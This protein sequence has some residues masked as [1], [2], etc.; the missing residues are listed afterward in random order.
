MSKRFNSIFYTEGKFGKGFRE[1]V[2]RGSKNLYSK[3]HY[4][5][6]ITP[7]DLPEDYVKFSSRTIWYMDGYVKTSG[8]VDI[9]YTSLK[10]NHLFKDDYLDVSY[11]NKI[12]LKRTEYGEQTS[13][14]DFSICGNDIIP[15]LLAIEKYSPNLDTSRARQQITDKFNWWKKNCREDYERWFSGKEIDDIIKYFAN[16]N[17]KQ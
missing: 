6:K 12:K 9:Y 2:N 5:T 15:V 11:T 16:K 17:P 4:P 1:V 14:Y 10:I 13:G 8:V 3:G 7:E